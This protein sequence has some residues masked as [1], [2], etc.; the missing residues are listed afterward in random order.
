MARPRSDIRVRILRAA[1][2]RFLMQGVDGASL[3]RIA[4]DAETSIAM[5]YYYF[6]TKD[7]LFAAIVEE[8]YEVALVDLTAALDPELPVEE[9]I[10]RLYR[11]IGAVSEEE[12]R[13]I[14]LVLREALVSSERLDRLF[15]RFQRGHLPYV[16][17]TIAEGLA[18]GTFDARLHPLAVLLS[19]VALGGPGQ[20][21]RRVVERRLPST[22]APAGE[23]LSELMVGVLLHGVGSKAPAAPVPG[24]SP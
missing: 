13:V 17:R 24:G 12:M 18:G 9:R 21:L 22:G 10:R 19:M 16:L 23:A 7:D 1:R 3:R 6:P 8:V 11:R 4:R 5:I 20:L 2:E 15:E 14:R